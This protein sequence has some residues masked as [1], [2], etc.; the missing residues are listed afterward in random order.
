MGN[1]SQWI[2]GLALGIVAALVGY[3]IGGLT[4]AGAIAAAVV[5]TLT[6]GGGGIAPA[7][8][9]LLFFFSSSALSRV[10]GERKRA[11][12]SFFSKKAQRDPGQVLA[13][14]ALAAGLS[15]VY[16]LG[17]SQAWFAGLS[18]ALAAVTADTWA[19]ELGVLAPGRPRLITT[20]EL[21][22]AG[23]SG[24]VSLLGSV[25]ATAGA[26]LIALAAGGFGVGRRVIPASLIGG[27]AG[28]V[29]DSLLGATVQTSYFCPECK[30]QTERHPLHTC[31][32]ETVHT[33]G[34][35]WMNNDGV[36]FVASVAGAVV[37]V[38]VWVVT[39]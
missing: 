6:M 23:T 7:V 18:G 37:A 20:G 31:G 19:T 14:G 32:T 28:V 21:V 9:L 11:A 1:S 22:E 33:R 8:L 24:G 29:L 39:G 38:G 12:Q 35:R 27:I 25:A 10:G 26:L 34:W 36:N 17:G 2:F 5:G 3:L 15:V 13:N 4:P 30:K 16:G